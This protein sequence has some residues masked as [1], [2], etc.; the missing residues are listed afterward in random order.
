MPWMVFG[1]FNE[2]SYPD[3]K[4]GWMDR[5]VKQMVAFRECLSRCGLYDLGFIGQIFTRCNGQL[6]SSVPFLD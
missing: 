4:L 2:I 1:D 3:E 6:G 5:D